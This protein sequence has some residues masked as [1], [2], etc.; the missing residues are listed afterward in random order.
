M[1]GMKNFL[2]ISFDAFKWPYKNIIPIVFAI[3]VISTWWLARWWTLWSI[4]NSFNCQFRFSKL[5]KFL[6]TETFIFLKKKASESPTGSGR[7]SFVSAAMKHMKRSA[8]IYFLFFHLIRYKTF[9][10]LTTI[11]ICKVITIVTRDNQICF[12]MSLVTKWCRHVFLRC[13]EIMSLFC[14]F[15]H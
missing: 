7:K 5:I 15:P 6:M 12:C 10:L 14:L 8:F 13:V 4:I 3:I 11:S 1:S 9:Q 2:A